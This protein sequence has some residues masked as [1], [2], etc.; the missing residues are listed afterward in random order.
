MIKSEELESIGGS[1]VLL[2]TPDSNRLVIAD[3]QGTVHVFDLET[4]TSLVSFPSQKTSLIQ[5]MAIS[6]DSQWLVTVNVQKRMVSYSLDELVPHQVLPSYPPSTHLSFLPSSP[7]LVITTVSNG[8]YIVD[9]TQNALTSWSKTNSHNLPK[10]FQSR[11]E[12]VRG[13]TPLSSNN[14]FLWGTSYTFPVDLKKDL[15]KDSHWK[16]NHRFQSLM[17]CEAI[18]QTGEVVIVERPVLQVLQELP[19]AFKRKKFGA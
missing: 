9:V 16:L 5:S 10:R 13:A 15:D 17:F 7:N 14:L 6:D 18:P 1:S 11:S 3:Y 4:L 12:I 2:F 8:I 19:D